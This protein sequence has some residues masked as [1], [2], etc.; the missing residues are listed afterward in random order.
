[1]GGVM[2]MEDL[3]NHLGSS[4][5]AIVQPLSTTYRGVTVHTT[6]PPSQGAILLEALNILEGFDLKGMRDW[7]GRR[8]E[9]ILRIWRLEIMEG[10][11]HL[12][13]L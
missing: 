8:R 11:C 2:T 13:R 12:A 4:E 1:M 6:P 7:E 3:E 5:P 9:T 10:V